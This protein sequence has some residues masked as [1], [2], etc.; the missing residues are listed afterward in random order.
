MATDKTKKMKTT[1]M[2]V[3]WYNT[4]RHRGQLKNNAG[5]RCWKDGIVRGYFSDFPL[6]PK[7]GDTDSMYPSVEH[8]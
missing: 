4:G 6:N 8:L 1:G 3:K 2:W 5:A 7:L